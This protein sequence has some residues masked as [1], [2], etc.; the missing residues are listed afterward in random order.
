MHEAYLEGSQQLAAAL[1]T[2]NVKKEVDGTRS[3][4]WPVFSV[5]L[6]SIQNLLFVLVSAH[7]AWRNKKQGRKDEERKLV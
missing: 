5:S 3:N 1:D 7:L 2:G 4:F 6:N